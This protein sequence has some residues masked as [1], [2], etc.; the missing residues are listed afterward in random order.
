MHHMKL[1]Y[2]RQRQSGLL[3]LAMHKPPPYQYYNCREDL[4]KAV[5]MCTPSPITKSKRHERTKHTNGKTRQGT[6]RPSY[7]WREC[8]GNSVK[9]TPV[10]QVHSLRAKTRHH[11][12]KMGPNHLFEHSEWSRITFGKTRFSPIFD[13]LL[14][15]KRPIFKAFWDFPWPITHYHGLKTA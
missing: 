1:L 14:V 3:A 2:A 8:E 5:R 11:G 4:A 7:T 10:L 9:S 13:P 6:T 12:L 15:P